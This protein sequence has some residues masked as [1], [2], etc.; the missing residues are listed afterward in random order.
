MMLGKDRPCL[1]AGALR[2]VSI[3][4]A[5]RAKILSESPRRRQKIAESFAVVGNTANHFNMDQISESGVTFVL[6]GPV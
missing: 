6:L 5:D 1:V 2:A 4:A 3:E